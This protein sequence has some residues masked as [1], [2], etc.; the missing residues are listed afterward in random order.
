MKVF[1]I[2]KKLLPRYEPLPFTGEINDENISTWIYDVVADYACCKAS[3][4]S[5]KTSIYHD[6]KI[7][8][9]DV[10]ELLDDISNKYDVSFDNFDVGNRFPSEIEECS[11][12]FSLRRMSGRG[13]VYVVTTLDDLI[14]YVLSEVKKDETMKVPTLGNQ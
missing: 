12:L 3:D 1:S 2:L 10:I 8:G 7:S 14:D 6:L 5:G 13:P 9:D 11:M 4:I